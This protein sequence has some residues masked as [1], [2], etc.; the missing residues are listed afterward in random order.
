MD[1]K[2]VQSI[3][4]QSEIVNASCADANLRRATRAVTQ[5]YDQILAPTG[6]Q[7]TQFT[8]LVACAVAGS[9]PITTLADALVMDRT[10]VARNLQPLEARGLVRV[11]AG[12]DRRVRMVMLKDKGYATLEKAL[13]LWQEA[14]T[15]VIEGFGEKRLNNLLHDLSAIVKLARE[16]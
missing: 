3:K 9:V 14:Q 7:T 11:A 10:T 13:P 2:L 6:L 1:E 16:S 15:Q 12:K 8:L 5:L 4:S